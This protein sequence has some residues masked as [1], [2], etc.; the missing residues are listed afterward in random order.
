MRKIYSLVLMA[1]GLL[2]SGNAWAVNQQNGHATQQEGDV[3]KVSVDV[4]GVITTTYYATLQDAFDD[5]PDNSYPTTITMLADV[6]TTNAQFNIAS[7]HNVTLDLNNKTISASETLAKNQCVILNNGTLTIV[8]NSIDGNGIITSTAEKPDGEHTVPG[9]ASNTITNYGTIYVKSGTINNVVTNPGDAQYAIDNTYGAT[10]VME[11]GRLLANKVAVRLQCQN[12]KVTSLLMQ[13]G[14]MLADS[15]S[16]WAQ[17]Y[18]GGTAAV[19]INGGTL[20][21]EGNV[22][23]IQL[24][25]TNGTDKGRAKVH[26]NGGTLYGNCELNVVTEECEITDGT[27]IQGTLKCNKAY[28]HNQIMTGGIFIGVSKDSVKVYKYLGYWGQNEHTATTIEDFMTNFSERGKVAEKSSKWF[29]NFGYDDGYGKGDYFDENANLLTSVYPGLT[30]DGVIAKFTSKEWE[31][32][33]YHDYDPSYS[34]GKYWALLEPIETQPSDYQKLRENIDGYIATGFYADE[35]DGNGHPDDDIIIRSTT[36]KNIVVGTDDEHTI[37]WTGNATESGQTNPQKTDVVNITNNDASNKVTLEINGDVD[38]FQIKVNGHHNSTPGEAQIVV[39][40]GKTLNVGNGGIVSENDVLTTV[41][42]ETGGTLIIGTNGIDKEG[43]ATPIEI[44]ASEENGTG[45]LIFS[46]NA[47]QED[48]K[49]YAEVDLYTYCKKVGEKYYWQQFAIPVTGLTND[50]VAKT[51]STTSYIFDWDYS[52]YSWHQ[53]DSWA[54]LE[55]P[56]AGYDMTNTSTTGG[57]VYTFKGDLIGNQNIQLSLPHKDYCIMGNSYTAPISIKALFEQIEKE[58]AESTIERTV[59]KYDAK[60]GYYVYTNAL[61]QTLAEMGIMEASFTEIK[62]MEGFFL[63]L[64]NGNTAGVML[65]YANAVFNPAMASASASA[66]ARQAATIDW[67]IAKMMVNSANYTDCMTLVEGDE[68]SADIEN[69]KDAYKYMNEDGI[70]LY[71]FND[72]A[73]LAMLASDNIE[74]T[75][76]A[77]Q[78]AADDEYTLTFQNVIN[79]NYELLDMQTGI[80]IPMIEGNAYTFTATP[81]TLNPSRFM[82]VASRATP[83]GTEKV[84]GIKQVKGIYTMLGQYMGAAEAWSSLPAGVYVVNGVQMAK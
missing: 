74:G 17:V 52:T 47:K 54:K 82:L 65:N 24:D 12:G 77:F 78:S 42:V 50:K 64:Q 14:E 67:T 39:K 28:P 11:G 44:K 2:I 68:F 35:Y 58:M 29:I 34:S 26:I 60:K 16:I 79:N 7:Y 51:P 71:A 66:P 75:N 57:V 10:L 37:T 32:L 4:A 31:V 70:N 41:L 9:Y 1:V 18:D 61:E 80:R 33:D 46:P 15:R 25:Q 76:I 45:V 55:T 23:S 20:G 59:Y 84:K 13:G 83:T 62:P 63:N 56:F 69:G 53:L 43:D 19:T 21:S 8:D 81:N 72:N 40:N 30:K 36:P 38:V 22:K 27:F 48:T 6:Q 73:K 49:Q 5:L 3:A